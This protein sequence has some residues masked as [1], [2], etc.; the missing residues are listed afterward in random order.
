MA[1][2]PYTISTLVPKSLYASQV[3]GL[4]AEARRHIAALPDEEFR[5]ERLDLLLRRLA[6]QSNVEASELFTLLRVSLAWP[7]AIPD[8][9]EVM[10]A[11]GRQG[12]LGRLDL[13]LTRLTDEAGR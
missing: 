11:L 6:D 7:D 12:I 2:V 8:L 9:F 1:G 13:A 4:L 5:R 10:L 3:K